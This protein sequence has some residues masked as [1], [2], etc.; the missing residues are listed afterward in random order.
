MWSFLKTA[1]RF[2][3]FASRSSSLSSS[4]SFPR[5]SRLVAAV[6]LRLCLRFRFRTSLLS[7]SSSLPSQFSN[8][9]TA[10]YIAQASYSAAN[11]KRTSVYIH[12]TNGST[13]KCVKLRKHV[14]GYLVLYALQKSTVYFTDKLNISYIIVIWFH[15]V[16]ICESIYTGN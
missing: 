15:I 13:L 3:C 7:L 5:T 1:M 6:S 10:S 14:P 12:N 4:S 2:L 11:D 16:K 8:N 9:E